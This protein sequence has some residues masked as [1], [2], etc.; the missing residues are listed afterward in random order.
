MKIDDAFYVY[1]QHWLCL[2]WQSNDI[3]ILFFRGRRKLK[4]L[5]R[6]IGLC[7]H[8]MASPAKQNIISNDRNTKQI[9]KKEF[10]VKQKQ[11]KTSEV[12]IPYNLNTR[13]DK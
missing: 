12:I 9:Q 8:S 5:S 13:R 11:S 4:H 7:L 3:M 1:F 6:W 2:T 10:Q